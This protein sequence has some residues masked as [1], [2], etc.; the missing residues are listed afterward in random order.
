MCQATRGTREVPGVGLGVAS[1]KKSRSGWRTAA[2]RAAGR[3]L[4]R[5]LRGRAHGGAARPRRARALRGPAVPGAVPRAVGARPSST[6]VSTGSRSSCRPR[7]ERLGYRDA[8]LGRG[9]RRSAAT[10]WKGSEVS[11]HRR[12]FDH[13]TRAEPARVLE[14]RLA[15]TRDRGAARRRH[16]PRA[17][18]RPSSSPSWSAPTTGPTT[19]SASWCASATSRRIW[20]T[21][22]S[23]SRTSASSSHRGVDLRRIVGALLANV[24]AGRHPPGRQHAHAA[25]RE[26]LLPD[27][28]AEL[29]AQAPGSRDGPD[30]RGPLREG[31]D[32]RGLSQRDLPRAARLDRDPRRRRGRA[33][34]LREERA[35]SR[36]RRVGADRGHHQEP[37]RALAACR[38]PRAR[39]R[40]PQSRARADARAG[41]HRR[42]RVRRRRKAEPL[43]LGEAHARAARGSLLP[44]RS[45]APAPATST[46]RPTLTDRRAADLLDARPAPP[47]R[48]R[49]RRARGARALEK[50]VPEARP[51]GESRLEGCL[52]A[53]RPQ[54]GEVLALVG[55]RD[56][57][58]SQFDR[59]TPGA[60]AGRQRLQAVRLRRGAR[61]ESSAGPRSRSRAWLDDSP[62][63]VATP[64]GPWRPKNFDQRVPRPRAAARGARALAQRGDGAARP[65]G[66]DP[67]GSPTWRVGSASRA[68]S[69]WC[70]ASRS[71]RPTSRRSSWRAPTPRSRTAASGPRIRT[72]E[73]VVEPTAGTLERQPIELERVLD[74]RHGLPRDV[75]ARGRR[76]PRHGR[77][78]CARRASP[79]RSPA[80][81]APATTSATP[82][83]SATRPSSWPWSGWASTSRAA[84][85][86]PRARSRS[87]SGGASCARRPGGGCA[88]RSCAPPDVEEIEID[89]ISGAVAL[90]G[91]PTRRVEYFLPGTEPATTCPGWVE[92]WRRSE[93]GE[94]NLLERIFDSW[95]DRL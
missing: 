32:P 10:A 37:E 93:P 92:P 11:I 34:L 53:L 86:S 70:R 85:A 16:R 95:L 27:A 28:R 46:A 23:P 89:P 55:G 12:A 63:A 5:R 1:R 3:G 47:A 59:C 65:A 15:G 39:A 73:D 64:S 81:P 18:R 52:V 51:K 91:C 20:S 87:R 19:S 8:R 90:A 74:P 41:P 71:A 56:Y 77:A 29:H 17:R 36:A 44:R 33:L 72:F 57:A 79:V 94:P 50:D 48:G 6:R 61:A 67:R 14:L 9:P 26:E 49:A 35:R 4:R 22:S 88:G 60:A 38:Q 66:G 58:T 54:T 40:A 24:R 42:R 7:C 62:L 25:A 45:P 78:R 82:G 21:R 68:R 84:S 31:R 13:P 43:G 80:R 83:S 69:R 75:A 76:R 2:R 30:R